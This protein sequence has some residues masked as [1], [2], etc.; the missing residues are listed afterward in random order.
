VTR[1]PSPVVAKGL[2]WGVALCVL[3]GV[4]A[5]GLQVVEQ[6][7]FGRAYVEALVVAILL[8]VLIA[9]VWR[10]PERFGPGIDFSARQLLEL[11]VCLIGVAI[12]TKLLRSAGPL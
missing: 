5:W 1:G 11:A 12:D 2:T 6:G 8:G 3:I 7:V 4:A 9:T 10:I